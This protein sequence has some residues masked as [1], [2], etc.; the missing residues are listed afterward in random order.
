M[1]NLATVLITI[2]LLTG[3][4]ETVNYAV[5]IHA[6]AS[7]SD[8]QVE[9]T[10]AES[11]VNYLAKTLYGEARGIESKME[12][13]AVCWCIL[14]RVDSNAWD[15]KD[16]NAIKDVVTAPDQFMGYD[17]DNPL[18][19]E[20]VEISEDVLV[21]W[22]MEKDGV[23]EVGRVLPKEYTHF[24]GDGE[25]NYFRKDWKVKEFWDWS[26]DNP[27]EEVKQP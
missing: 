11:D 1:N 27:Y 20:L 22:R 12:K 24:Y 3:G 26:L 7:A 14:N 10:I 17:K 23:V 25:R 16:M 4:T 6:E 19:D 15:F 18:V 8:V 9:Y 13:A 2:S 5:P 21:R